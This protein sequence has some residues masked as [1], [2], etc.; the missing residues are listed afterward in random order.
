MNTR[1]NDAKA[2]EIAAD[3]PFDRRVVRSKDVLLQVVDGEAVLLHAA[4]GEYYGLNRV[5]TAMWQSLDGGT[6][7]AAAY[8]KLADQFDVERERLKADLTHLIGDLLAHGL[9]RLDP[10]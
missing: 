1:S 8:E 9:V 5:G 7:I 2:C 10:P 6:T 4:R 3:V